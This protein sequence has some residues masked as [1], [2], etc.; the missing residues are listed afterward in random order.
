MH[1]LIKGCFISTFLVATSYA[2]DEGPKLPSYAKTLPEL[3]AAKDTGG[4]GGSE[5]S[6]VQVVTI[7]GNPAAPGPYAQLLKV[8]QGARIAP[9]HHAGDR[10]ATV[11]SGTWYFGYGAERAEKELR[12]LPQGS[13]YTE[14]S[15]AAH[16]AETHG[17]PVV[18]LITGTGPTDT[19][20]ENT[21]DDPRTVKK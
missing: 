2:A 13:V 21:A 17:E 18:I 19:V 4:P 20:Y 3:L 14:P 12:A 7:L 11:L 6:K 1:T 10:V 8:K 16:Y 5:N 9:H 15:N